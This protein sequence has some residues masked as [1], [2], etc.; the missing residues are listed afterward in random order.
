MAELWCQP[1]DRDQ[2]L[3]GV[4][5]GIAR[6]HRCRQAAGR[7]NAKGVRIGDRMLALDLRRLPHQWEIDCYQLDGQLFQEMKEGCPYRAARI[8]PTRAPYERD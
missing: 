6:Q 7:G 8:F 3:D 1:P 2:M 4:K 5:F